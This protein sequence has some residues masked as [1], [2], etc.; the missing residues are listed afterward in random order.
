MIYLDSFKLLDKDAEYGIISN[1]LNI[2]NNLYP[3]RVFS[4]KELT[5]KEFESITFFMV[6]M[7]QVNQLS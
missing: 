2:Y 6:V 3:L 7:D 4:N 1:K 5:Y